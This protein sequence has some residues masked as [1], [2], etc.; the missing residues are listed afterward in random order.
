MGERNMLLSFS[1]LKDTREPAD[2]QAMSARRS[3]HLQNSTPYK[4]EDTRRASH[5]AATNQQQ[6]PPPLAS[7]PDET[8]AASAE[9]SSHEEAP[10]AHRLGDAVDDNDTDN[11]PSADSVLIA[12]SQEAP[13]PQQQLSQPSATRRRPTDAHTARAKSPAPHATTR[14]ESRVP[15]K[16][17]A[18]LQ[19]ASK[20]NADRLMPTHAK[21]LSV[22]AVRDE[23]EPE[24]SQSAMSTHRTTTTKHVTERPRTKAVKRARSPQ[25]TA[26]PNADTNGQPPVPEI[27][28]GEGSAIP[29]ARRVRVENELTST[30]STKTSH[31]MTKELALLQTTSKTFADRYQPK[32]VKRQHKQVVHK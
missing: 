17:I 15:A 30:Q 23:N 22:P 1:A 26:Q 25:R 20:T 14:E 19:A 31:G 8:M 6:P 28:D 4:D 16:E 10:D 9:S 2:T 5:V 13:V 7:L 27:A 11:Q 32:S 12:G 21:R 3:T 24:S 18:S 29:P